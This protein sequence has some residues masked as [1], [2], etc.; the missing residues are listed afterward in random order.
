MNKREECLRKSCEIVNGQREKSYGTP[1]NNFKV[2][3]EMWSAYLDVDVSAV[4]EN[5]I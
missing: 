3:A 2:I 1:E 4:K 5:H